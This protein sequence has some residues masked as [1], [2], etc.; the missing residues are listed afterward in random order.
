[1]LSQQREERRKARIVQVRQQEKDFA[2]KVRDNVRT[3]KEE[4]RR[5]IE[6]RLQGVLAASE[7][8]EL[9]ELEARYQLR[10]KQMGLGHREAQHVILVS[11]LVRVCVYPS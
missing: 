2:K 8:A 3:K 11:L 7:E 6:E 9:R 5:A 1:M 4:E 10:E